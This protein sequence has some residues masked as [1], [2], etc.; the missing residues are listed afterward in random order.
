[1]ELPL[2]GYNERTPIS[3][4]VS[5]PDVRHVP[6][7][8]MRALRVLVVDDMATN[9]DIAASFIRSAGHQVACAEGGA[10]AVEAVASADFDVVLMDVRMPGMDGLEA[11]RRIR[12]LEGLRGQVPIVA[13]TGQVFSEQ[14]EECRAV[15]MDGYVAK[16]Y[17][18][19]S[20][21]EALASAQIRED[22]A[23]QVVS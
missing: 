13:V 12:A 22:R 10:E 4:A 15:G 9:L 18:L 7:V 14:L 2:I 3:A 5:A 11:T 19:E 17:K 20:L 1:L 16:P 23:R 21:L 8:P 6:L